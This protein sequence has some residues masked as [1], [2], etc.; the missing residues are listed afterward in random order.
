MQFVF[1]GTGL[2]SEK[3]RGKHDRPELNSLGTQWAVSARHMGK[4]TR[5]LACFKHLKYLLYLPQTC[6]GQVPDLIYTAY[7]PMTFHHFL[8]ILVGKEVVIDLL[9]K[10]SIILKFANRQL[11][12][13]QPNLRTIHNF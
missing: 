2:Y 1:T 4:S 8:Q 6:A 9:Y 12:Q 7:S 5:K 10:R 11:A 13:L 3:D